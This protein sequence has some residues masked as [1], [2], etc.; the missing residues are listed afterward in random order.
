MENMVFIAPGI[1]LVRT[2]SG[3]KKAIKD[4]F[5]ECFGDWEYYAKNISGYPKSYPAVVSLSV[6]YR[7]ATCFQCNCVHVNVLKEAIKEA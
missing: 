2:Q 1:Y 3:F 5:S 7:G 6:G 4:N